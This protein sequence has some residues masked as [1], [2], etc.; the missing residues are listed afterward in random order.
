MAHTWRENAI[1]S[2]EG[3]KQ[4]DENYDRIFNKHM[5]NNDS[6]VAQIAQELRTRG[7]KVVKSVFWNHNVGNL[8][9]FNKDGSVY[10][11]PKEGVL[12]PDL[13][14]SDICDL[15]DQR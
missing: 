6:L 2:T 4:Y 15:I 5:D 9:I 11:L 8:S 10:N 12:D 3:K 1:W 13:S 14:V 7:N